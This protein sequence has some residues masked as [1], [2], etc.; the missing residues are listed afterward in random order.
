[1]PK[2]DKFSGEENENT[3]E[4]IARFMTQCR[5]VAA[6]PFLKM[7]LFSKSL[8]KTVFFWYTSLSHNSVRDWDELEAKFHELFYRAV[9]E[10]SIAD[11]ASYRKSA[12]E[13]VEE[14][15]NRFK[16]V[17]NHCFVRVPEFE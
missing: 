12:G 6:S 9:P 17:R 14:Y 10:L 3:I 16:A 11:I 2:F 5:E 8:T 1:M 13:T 7:R 15:L 4:H